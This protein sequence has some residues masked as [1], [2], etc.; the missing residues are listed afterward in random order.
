MEI[1]YEQP[2]IYKMAKEVAD[3]AMDE[4]EIDGKT[5]RQWIK[6]V[7]EYY[8]KKEQGKIVELLCKPGD[9]VYSYCEELQRILP[10]FVEQVVMDYDSEN[11]D[12]YITIN[13]NCVE[14]NEL[15]DCIDF[16]PKEIGKKAFL[17][18]QEAKEALERMK[19]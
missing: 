9:T 19:E 13:A 14:N 2:P 17:T 5:L 16:E 7:E 11:T 12:G 8:L 4:F 18:E 1:K 15:I 10:Y 6:E 3:K